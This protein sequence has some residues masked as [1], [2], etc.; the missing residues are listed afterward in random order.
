MPKII[1]IP[2]DK[3]HEEEIKKYALELEY[4]EPRPNRSVV[5]LDNLKEQGIEVSDGGKFANDLIDKIDATLPLFKLPVRQRQ[6]VELRLAG[7]S[8][9]NIA[10]RMG[11]SIRTAQHY[12]EKA[13]KKLK[14][15]LV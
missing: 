10:E 4:P 15:I 11:I 3:K 6:V 1:K 9:K 5:S 8:Y 14:T 13:Q 2:Y 12:K 7:C